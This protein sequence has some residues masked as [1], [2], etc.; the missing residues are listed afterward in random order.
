MS[1]LSKRLMVAA[2]SGAL[3]VPNLTTA[4]AAP[5][6]GWRDHGGHNQQ[7]RKRPNPKRHKNNDNLGAAVA[8]GIIGLAAGAI[9]LGATSQPSYAGPPA[10]PH[11]P[12][13]PYPGPA[14]GP[15]GFQPW[16]P[17][18]YRYCSQKY[19]SFN[20]ATGTYMTYRG[21]ERFCR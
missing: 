5:K 16:S 21:V 6:H 11:Y 3:L 7:H 19:R 17:A 8:A 9:L 18:W 20:P 12:P 15:V 2:L 14:A 13:P 10:Q 1:T 4:E